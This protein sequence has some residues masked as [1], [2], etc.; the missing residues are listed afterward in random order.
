[1][2]GP[3]AAERQPHRGVDRASILERYTLVRAATVRLT[4][5]LT[6]ED[7][8]VQSM[9]DASPAKW[10][11]AHT[12]WFFETFLLEPSLAD[13]RPFDPDFGYLFNSYYEAVGPRHARPERGL[14]TRPGLERVMGYRTHV[15]R[16]MTA[17]IETLPDTELAS[18]IPLITLGL[19]HEQQHQ[20]LILMDIKHAFSRNPL[21]PTFRERTIRGAVAAPPV[22]W[23][24]VEGGLRRIGHDGDGF[25]FDNEGPR[26]KVWLEP[27]ALADRLVTAGDYLAFI[28]DG[29]YRRPEFW[30]SDGWAAVQAHG[31][32]APLYWREEAP[33]AWSMFTLEGRRPLDPNEPV[34]HLNF[35]EADAFALWAG[36]RL[37]T[38]AEWEVA[39]ETASPLAEALHLHPNAASDGAGPRQLFGEVWQWTSSAYRPY[40]GFRAAPG[41]V[42]EYNGKF[43]SGQMVLRGSACVTPP[44]HARIT[45]RNFF[46]PD[47]RWAF[48]GLRLARDA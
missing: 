20:E 17:M 13:Y 27:F 46:P 41:A 26:H 19:Q 28:D 32:S 33:G 37:P 6:P 12:A 24:P 10:H 31:W 44:G 16:A 48:S 8:L 4:A 23:S 35:Y 29:G 7:A 39:A 21:E 47:A 34:C 45:Y 25:A 36:A 5:D 18:A 42:G 15:D 43:M 38:E 9:P 3:S 22:R 30:L 2:D 14:L 40:P 11:L 1:M